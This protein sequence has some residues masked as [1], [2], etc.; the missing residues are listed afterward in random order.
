MNRDQKI[1]NI[2][3]GENVNLYSFLPTGRKIW[4]VKTPNGLHTVIENKL[5]CTCG[6][7]YFSVLS[8]K[9][10]NCYHIDI[11][12]IAKTTKQYS[13]IECNDIDFGNF[14]RTTLT[15]SVL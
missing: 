8:G 4:T 2:L 12:R 10:D 1:K 14:L 3:D 6:H 15:E 7:F 9:D 11:I 13:I 5:Y